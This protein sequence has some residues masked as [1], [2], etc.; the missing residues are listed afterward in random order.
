MRFIVV[1]WVVVGAVVALSCDAPLDEEGAPPEG[2]VQHVALPLCPVDG[3]TTPTDIT[4]TTPTST[5]SCDCVTASDCGVAAS[6]HH[7]VCSCLCSLV[8]D[9]SGACDDGNPCTINDACDSTGACVGG[10]AN[11]CDDH[12]GCTIDSCDTA[13]GCHHTPATMYPWYRDADGDGYGN[14]LAMISNCVQVTG[15]VA[16]N[17]DCDDS[18]PNVYPGATEICGNGKDDNCNRIVDTDAPTVAM[19]YRDL[20]GDGYGSSASGTTTGCSPPA[21]YVNNNTD[22]DDTNAQVHP[23]A[24]ELCNGKDDNCVGGADEGLGTITCGTGLCMTTVPACVGGV[25]KTCVPSCPDSGAD[26][27]SG[28]ASSGSDARSE[29]RTNV[30][31][32]SSGDARADVVTSRD[33]VAES[34]HRLDA[35]QPPDEPPITLR[36]AAEDTVP[37]GAGGG[38][39]GGTTNTGGGA[40]VD[41]SGDP[42]LETFQR[43]LSCAV[44][45][46]RHGDRPW[47]VAASMLIA[48]ALG[49]RKPRRR[50]SERSP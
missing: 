6:C 34:A 38:S 23:G 48:V 43:N 45:A 41:A 36:D 25:A 47:A 35:D 11:T 2:T 42:T 27:A 20:D 8:A 40:V 31:A 1:G 49:R 29:A 19:F 33:A 39:A 16:D 30:D 13:T 46:R 5:T 15:Y 12:E 7:W 28:D 26:G 17:T 24:P 9:T 10:G 37:R 14:P 32:S 21:G 50:S 18:D 4:D 3:C 22:C 44:S